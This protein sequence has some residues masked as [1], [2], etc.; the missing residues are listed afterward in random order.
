MHEHKR[1][2]LF[3]KLT[4]AQRILPKCSTLHWSVNECYQKVP[5]YRPVA[6]RDKSYYLLTRVSLEKIQDEEGN[7][8]AFHGLNGLQEDMRGFKSGKHIE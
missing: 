4:L 7:V 8:A 1:S 3:N 2:G 6:L 5:G